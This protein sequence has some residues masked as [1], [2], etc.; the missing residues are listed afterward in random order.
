MSQGD[1]TFNATQRIAVLIRELREARSINEESFLIDAIERIRLRADAEEKL[2]SWNPDVPFP[3][4]QLREL[5]HA[6][7][8]TLRRKFAHRA[9]DVAKIVKDS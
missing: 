3:A 9:D 1:P 4:D 5:D 6:T 7:L 2:Q 8:E